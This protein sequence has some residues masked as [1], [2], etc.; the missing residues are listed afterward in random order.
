MKLS[1]EFLLSLNIILPLIASMASFIRPISFNRILLILIGLLLVMANILILLNYQSNSSSLVLAN[2]LNQQL[3]LRAEP[4]AIIF[5]LMVSILWCL[6]NLYSF[7]YLIPFSTSSLTE[8]SAGDR[9][10][11]EAKLLRSPVASL[12]R[13]ARDDAE[14]DIIGQKQS[15]LEQDLNPKIHFFFTPLAI[16]ASLAIGYSD[17]LLTLFIF[18]E[19]LT[20]STYPLVIQSF[21]Q[22]AKKAGKIYLTMLFSSSAF[23]LLFALIFIDSNYTS[24]SFKQGGIFSENLE[25]HIFFFLLICFV[26]GISKTAIFPLYKW[27]P[28]AMVAPTP[29]SALLHA[30]AVVKSGIFALIKI[31][32]Y[33]FGIDYLANMH[34]IFP[35]TIDWLTLLACFTMLY[36]GFLALKQDSLKKMLAYSTI[37]QLSYPI[38][39]LS[40]TSHQTMIAAFMQ[41]LAHAI[42]K[43]TLFFAA[44]IIYI[45]LFILVK[46][47]P[48]LE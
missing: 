31:F 42:A 17:N 29:V 35:W 14:N 34:K 28:E 19:L 37:S 25:P 1:I 48:L 15:N 13:L 20:F 7:F 26:F 23:F 33:L 40:F 32:V 41:M 4:L 45:N 9:G 12:K 11:L 6:T 16:M 46:C 21:S 8:A 39:A 43:I 30:V 27:L 47:N 24:S 2:I 18:Y 38:L 10:Y 5:S 36:A 22:L 44:G 3:A